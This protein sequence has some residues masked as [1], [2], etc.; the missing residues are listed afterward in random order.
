MKI[1]IVTVPYITADKHYNLAKRSYESF[2]SEHELLRV[3]VV[4]KVRNEEDLEL[5]YRQN[6]ITVKNR[7]SSLS[8]AWNKGI[9]I[10]LNNKCDYCLL[11]NLDVEFKPDSI[12]NLVLF[13]EKHPNAGLWSMQ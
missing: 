8:S 1:A 6:D 4:N 12:D 10:A 9:E 3:A 2:K 11:P 5:I 13:A 7:K